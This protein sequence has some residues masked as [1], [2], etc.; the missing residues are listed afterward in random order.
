M[1]ILFRRLRRYTSL[2]PQVLLLKVRRRLVR[3][4]KRYL[5]QLYD[6][7]AGSF[8]RRPIEKPL[9]S[10]V[11]SFPLREVSLQ[12]SA[13]RV[14]CDHYLAHR[15]DLLGSGW[16]AVGYGTVC[17]G[18]EDYRY[19]VD[20]NSSLR[21]RINKSNRKK[22][23]F[24]YSLIDREYTPIDWQLDFKSGYRWKESTWHMDIAIPQASPGADIKVP[25]ELARGQHLPQLAIA[26]GLAH[27]NISGFHSSER[28]KREFRN[29][30]LD[31]IANNPPRF[32]VNWVCA[33]DVGI[34]VAN[35]LL[36]YDLFRS[37]GA[38]FDSAFDD[39]FK[40]S[41]YEH[42][43]HLA[44]NLEWND[45]SRSNHYL[46]DLVGLLYAGAYLPADEDT[47]YWI[48]LSA[49]E[50]RRE[51]MLQFNNDGSNFEGST[52]YHRLS[53]EMFVYSAA[54]MLSTASDRMPLPWQD[55]S[56]KWKSKPDA[57]QKPIA[58]K[59]ELIPPELAL[60][61]ER[62]AEFTMHITRPDNHVAQIGD[63]DS[64]RLFK[65]QPAYCSP[66][67]NEPFCDYPRSFANT[68]QPVA[69][70]CMSE[71]SLDHRH[72]VGALGALFDR[73][74]CMEFAASYQVDSAIIRQ[75]CRGHR[76]DRTGPNG[77]PA[78]AS[79]VRI[80]VDE[81]FEQIERS[82]SAMPSQ[83]Y[84][85][86]APL[87]D[88]TKQCELFGYSEFGVYV[89]KDSR[90]FLTVRCGPA[91]QP[92][93]GAHAHNDQLSVELVIDGIPRALD[94]G[95]YLYTA[96]RYRRNEYRS[97]RAHFAPQID[98]MEPGDMRELFML[99]DSTRARCLYFGSRGFIGCHDGYGR[100]VYRVI[101]LEDNAIEIRDYAD[102]LPL[103]RCLFSGTSEQPEQFIGVPFSPGYGL[104]HS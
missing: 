93:I 76:L 13:L 38:K 6:G 29:Q 16:V 63:N 56:Q 100:S 102:G 57:P 25:W 7:F 103:K 30:L 44:A 17:L 42:G 71:N 82:L 37:T 11:T 60:R 70:E 18:V 5:Q 68:N 73:A 69:L 59:S 51:L 99:A 94:P 8:V 4:I 21:T 1:I 43:Q 95:S 24:V 53:A 15:F 36:A 85:F 66:S 89:I 41:V 86:C 31:F 74:D 62:A 50:L 61:L 64:G 34:R 45:A 101:N 92:G 78:P 49:H 2:P 28:Y 83:H 96:L 39:V 10:H 52:S 12:Y 27:A 23:N 55:V 65:L 3:M 75:L 79:L 47:N 58:L 33:M 97:V 84:R 20:A 80:G 90:L 77:C 54:L 48:C 46:A 22:A 35:W 26:H 72:L 87:A 14:A 91:G 88:R 19:R 81:E 32:G 98:G 40:R 9:F 67:G 104:R